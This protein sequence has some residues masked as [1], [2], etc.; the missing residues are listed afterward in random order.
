MI[1]GFL[2]Y[3]LILGWVM[4][5]LKWRTFVEHNSVQHL[6]LVERAPW[7]LLY[8]GVPFDIQREFVHVASIENVPHRFDGQIHHQ[9][10]PPGRE[11]GSDATK[12]SVSHLF[13]VTEVNWNGNVLQNLKPFM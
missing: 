7:N 11:F 5:E 4:S 1:L 8:F 9:I 12:E 6:A 2:M 13:I 3:L 10:L